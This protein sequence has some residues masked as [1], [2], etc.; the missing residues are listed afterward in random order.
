[1]TFIFFNLCRVAI[2]RSDFAENIGR[3][4]VN[5]CN[6]ESGTYVLKYVRI[7]EPVTYKSKLEV[8]G[9]SSVFFM[10]KYTETN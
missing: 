9:S 5:L 2:E 6:V 8:L 1:M 7:R 10:Q 4:V 3:A